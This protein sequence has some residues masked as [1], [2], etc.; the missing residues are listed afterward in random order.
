[1]IRFLNVYY[2]AR[3]M[4]LLICEAII[5][6]ACFVIAAFAVL[7][8]DTWLVLNYDYGAL[9]LAGV[10]VVSLLFS[11]YFDLYEPQ[12]VSGRQQIYF[13]IL[14]VL[15]FDCFVISAL[16]FLFPETGLSRGY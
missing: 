3:T 10:T 8:E 11:Y 1:M 9:K 15:G 16:L 5:V 13:R 12:L 4:M 2:P 6:G 7:H 14:L